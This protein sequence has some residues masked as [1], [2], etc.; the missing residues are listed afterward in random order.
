MLIT[1]W[2]AFQKIIQ[3]G[4]NQYYWSN[5][6]VYSFLFGKFSELFLKFTFKDVTHYIY[7]FELQR[8]RFKFLA[9]LESV[10]WYSY[11]LFRCC[12]PY[13]CITYTHTHTHTVQ[14]FKYCVSISNQYKQLYLNMT[15]SELI[16]V[17]LTLSNMLDLSFVNRT[18]FTK[19]FNIQTPLCISTIVNNNHNKKSFSPSNI[20]Y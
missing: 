10:L 11:F 17:H 16:G 4:T 3:Q 14:G 1:R 8:S 9:Q 15:S 20:I 7:I 2:T 5:G 6:V 12:T 18:N 13:A 19:D